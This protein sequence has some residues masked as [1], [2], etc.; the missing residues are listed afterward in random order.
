MQE[1]QKWKSTKLAV[2]NLCRRHNLPSDAICRQITSNTIVSTS[3]G[4][5]Y[6]GVVR[7]GM[8]QKEWPVLP[9][10][11]RV[12]VSKHKSRI[13]T[14]V[15]PFVLRI[16][17][18]VNTGQGLP[19]QVPLELYWQAAKVT[20]DEISDQGVAGANYFKRR[21]AIYEKGKVKRRYIV[22][23]KKIAG[24]VFGDSNKLV[25]YQSSRVHYCRPYERAV[26]QTDAFK[27][28]DEL[29]DMGV[30][31]LLVGPDGY[32]VETSWQE[33]Y[34]DTSKP[35][36]HERVLACMLDTEDLPWE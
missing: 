24:A 31:V 1:E 21:K 32:A 17:A 35:F 9:T 10:G 3:R 8:S 22:K 13:G 11:V 23:D 15:S 6:T 33:A 34:M 25:P 12:M 7:R 2:R 36:G 19:R 28:L 20:E 26:R 5:V 4:R 16:P 30:D 18:D 14:Q 29:L 27:F